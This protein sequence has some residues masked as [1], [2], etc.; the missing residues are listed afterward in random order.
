MTVAC[1]KEKEMNSRELS[2][3]S[4]VR[5]ESN[6]QTKKSKFSEIFFRYVVIGRR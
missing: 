4:S 2:D 3:I 1:S 6:C 5:K